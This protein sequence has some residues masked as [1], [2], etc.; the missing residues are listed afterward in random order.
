MQA[1][2]LGKADNGT[3]DYQRRERFET[4]VEAV[5]MRNF[6]RFEVWGLELTKKD[7]DVVVKSVLVKR[8]AAQRVQ[9]AWEMGGL[10]RFIESGQGIRLC[11]VDI[12][13]R[14]KGKLRTTKGIQAEGI[15][16]AKALRQQN[17]CCV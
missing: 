11:W 6:A 5:F 10:Y 2:G 7:I 16:S 3:V 4:E 13:Q 12:C 9:G 14:P 8:K 17:S 15:A 1:W